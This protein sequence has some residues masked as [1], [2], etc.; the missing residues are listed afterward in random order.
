[1]SSTDAPSGWSR[2]ALAAAVAIPTA[3]AAATAGLLYLQ[4][5]RES[6]QGTA[7]ATGAK[8]SK[9]KSSKSAKSAKSSA[10]PVTD[11][12]D[13]PSDEAFVLA[14][15]AD[16]EARTT[17]GPI[18]ALEERIWRNIR[19]ITPANVRNIAPTARTEIGQ[20]I[21]AFH[22][23]AAPVSG[24]TAGGAAGTGATKYHRVALDY[25]IAWSLLSSVE[26]DIGAMPVDARTP[27][28]EELRKSTELVLLDLAHKMRKPDRMLDLYKRVRAR[29][30]TLTPAGIVDAQQF[31]EMEF[32]TL[33]MLSPLL[34][35]WHDFQAWSEFMIEKGQSLDEF[36]HLATQRPDLIDFRQTYRMVAAAARQGRLAPRA[37]ATATEA[38]A[39]ASEEVVKV[40][41]KI[42]FDENGE[43]STLIELAP[44][45]SLLQWAE[46]PASELDWGLYDIVGTVWTFLRS[47]GEDTDSIEKYV[48]NRQP[49]GEWKDIDA[50]LVYFR[51]IGA[52]ARIQSMIA[53]AVPICG[54]LM[55]VHA[56]DAA[57]AEVT[58]TFNCEGG[59][60]YR[61]EAPAG[62]GGQSAG[63]KRLLRLVESYRDFVQLPASEVQDTIR[64][65][66]PAPKI[67]T[68]EAK[69]DD[70]T[71]DAAVSS[72]VDAPVD[73][74]LTVEE[75]DPADP[76]QI[77]RGTYIFE[78]FAVQ[79]VIETFGGR[80]FGTRHVSAAE[81]FMH[82]EYEVLL[83]MKKSPVQS[84]PTM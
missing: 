29:N 11:L 5:A 4:Y 40:E 34:G 51:K 69:T 79:E 48:A 66:R 67:E 44:T 1:M 45:G 72:P 38:A 39:A 83:K 16:I 61:S 73:A 55:H 76:P 30:T 10:L 15:H 82:V 9:K 64:K 8:K 46:P 60:N 63:P 6:K 70:A 84:A 57:D 50:G 18:A 20:W 35:Q 19:R 43:A 47:S 14:L 52:C 42:A 25:D 12:D 21:V 31:T 62:T 81:P 37:G 58:P 75:Y 17:K 33:W 56:S 13:F 32:F 80:P 24:G 71:A 22:A 27:T 7:A 53:A 26:S 28:E 23:N 36:H 74:P 54:P 68:A 49:E 65:W 59:V 41:V 2:R 3:V 78:Q 77:W